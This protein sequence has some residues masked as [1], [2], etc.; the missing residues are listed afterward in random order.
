MKND[1]Q[2]E[3]KINLTFDKNSCQ[4]ENRVLFGHFCSIT[5]WIQRRERES[6]RNEEK[7][8]ESVNRITRQTKEE[9]LF[10]IKKYWRRKK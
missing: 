3:T 6:E 5:S 8:I 9:S 2:T 10:L 7:S 1:G 4:R